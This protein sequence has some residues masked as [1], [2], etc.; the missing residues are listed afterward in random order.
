L[1]PEIVGRL[2]AAAAASLQLVPASILFRHQI[3]ACICIFAGSKRN[4]PACVSASLPATSRDRR[5]D[6]ISIALA[7]SETRRGTA[8]SLGV[9]AMEAATLVVVHGA[10]R[11][12]TCRWLRQTEIVA[13]DV[14]VHASLDVFAGEHGSI[15]HH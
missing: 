4:E 11:G 7:G 13:A 8:V 10:P 12:A 6:N 14:V 15:W 3:I 5:D 2:A 1:A 9:M